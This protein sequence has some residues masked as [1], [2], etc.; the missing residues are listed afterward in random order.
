MFYMPGFSVLVL[1][2]SSSY[3]IVDWNVVVNNENAEYVFV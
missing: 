1:A 3:Y 2:D